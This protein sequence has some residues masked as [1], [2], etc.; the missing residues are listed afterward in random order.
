MEGS[1][2][3]GSGGASIYGGKFNDEKVALKL[4]HEQGRRSWLRQLWE[5]RFSRVPILSSLLWHAKHMPLSLPFHCHGLQLQASHCL[6][7]Y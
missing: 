3:D 2:G 1:A 4:K 5:G 6:A 7:Y